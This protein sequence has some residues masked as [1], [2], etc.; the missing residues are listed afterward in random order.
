MTSWKSWKNDTTSTRPG[1]IVRVSGLGTLAG[2]DLCVRPGAWGGDHIPFDLDEL[3]LTIATKIACWNENATLKD[4]T[5]L[6]V[7]V[8]TSK[9]V[10]WIEAQVLSELIND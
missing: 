1:C 10:G 2:E 8:L 5:V 7:M 9:G 4:Y 6:W 3:A